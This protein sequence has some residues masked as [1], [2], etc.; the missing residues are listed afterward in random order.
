LTAEPL[1]VLLVED[2]EDDFLLARG[3]LSEVGGRKV[4]LRWAASYQEALR[5]IESGGHDVCLVDYRLGE[6]TGLELLREVRC[7]DCK[8]PM[9]MLTSQNDYDLDAEAMRAGAADYLVKGR[10]DTSTIERSIRYALQ[11]SS[12][13]ER[14]RGLADHDE[15]TGLYNRRAL[16]GLLRDE[17]SRH[18]RYGRP[19]SLVMLD[20]DYFKA[21]N[22]SYGHPVG[23]EVLRWLAQLVRDCVRAGDIPARY[24][25]EE[26]AVVLPGVDS[27][28]ALKAAERLRLRVAARPFSFGSARR[29]THLSVTL[30]LGV[31]ALPDDAPTVASL[32][33]AADRALYAAKRGGRNRSVRF[34]DLPE[35]AGQTGGGL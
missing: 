2:D 32:I 21:V 34:C 29:Q 31:A 30:S 3:L 27:G 24:G 6:R 12:Q 10:V 5:A 19:F 15:L 22:D 33:A 13:F 7:G 25:G 11:R 16:D 4:D 28:P 35:R 1:K 18:E 20:V 17:V 26:L 23:D 8:A 14:L 9:I